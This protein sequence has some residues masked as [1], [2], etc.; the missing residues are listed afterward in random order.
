M[1]GCRNSERGENG[2]CAGECLHQGGAIAERLHDSN[3]RSA[4]HVGYAF[5]PRTDDGSETHSFCPAHTEYSLTEPTCS[6]ND[7]HMMRQWSSLA[8]GSRGRHG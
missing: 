2:I 3:A 5:R 7:G 1:R 6:A 4:R 8:I